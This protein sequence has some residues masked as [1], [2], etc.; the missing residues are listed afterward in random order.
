MCRK[1]LNFCM[2]TF[3]SRLCSVKS[4]SAKTSLPVEH[5]GLKKSLPE[6]PGLE[7]FIANPGRP[8]PLRVTPTPP[9]IH[10]YIDEKTLNGNG[11]KG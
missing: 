2:R 11:R 10:P 8:R 1:S 7:H 3:N 4:A 9:E 5:P 6:G